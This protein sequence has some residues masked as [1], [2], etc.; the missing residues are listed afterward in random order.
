MEKRG[1][2][3]E[4]SA[5]VPMLEKGSETIGIWNAVY[6]GQIDSHLIVAV[7]A[8]SDC[9]VAA[10]RFD[11]DTKLNGGGSLSY[12]HPQPIY[13]LFNPWCPNDSVYMPGKLS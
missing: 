8:A 11:I 4:S 1:P 6:E 5:A 10:W 7:T 3:D 12:T 13:V 9:I 2:S